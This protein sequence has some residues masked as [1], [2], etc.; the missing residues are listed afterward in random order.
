MSRQP[1]FHKPAGAQY[2][3]RMKHG[4]DI[5]IGQDN[6]KKERFLKRIVFSSEDYSN[7]EEIFEEKDEIKLL[8]GAI[9]EIEPFYK[10]VPNSSASFPT[11]PKEL[12]DH[13]TKLFN[14]VQIDE[15]CQSLQK[16]KE[17]ANKAL[18]DLSK[19]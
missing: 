8:L 17:K 11:N 10:N 13:V 16:Q 2:N 4:P 6:V 7:F 3:D 18:A 5:S 9:K 15:T 19:Q 1:P 14:A 12:K